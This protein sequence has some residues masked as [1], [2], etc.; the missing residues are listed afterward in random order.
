MASNDLKQWL[1]DLMEELESIKKNNVWE[2]T[3]LSDMRK[4]IGYKWVLKKNNNVDSSLDKYKVRLVAEGFAKKS[5]VALIDKCSPTVKFTS[6]RIIM[7]VVVRMNL[8]LHQLDVKMEFLNGESKEDISM[9]QPESF[10]DKGYEGKVYKF[11]RSLYG[12]KQTSR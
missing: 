2:L 5:G 10:Q 3:T 8:N 1:D 4:S 7:F 9:P 11:E 6:V 12:L